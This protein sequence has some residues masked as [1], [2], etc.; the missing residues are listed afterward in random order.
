MRKRNTSSVLNL[1]I[2][3]CAASTILAANAALSNAILG[4]TGTKIVPYDEGSTEDLPSAAARICG[5]RCSSVFGGCSYTFEIEVFETCWKPIYSIR[6]DELGAGLIE[7]L[8][9]PSGWTAQKIPSML[10]APGT[11]VFSTMTNPIEPGIILPGFAIVLYAGSITFRWYPAD[12]EG[13]LVGKAS[14]IE[15]DCTTGTESQTWGSIKAVY[16]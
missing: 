16:R 7:P 3:V 5:L 8:S 10:H 4:A 12:H 2:L 6:I 9:W 13:I 11:T 14:R 1:A 15:L